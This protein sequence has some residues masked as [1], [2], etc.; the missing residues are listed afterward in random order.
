MKTCRLSFIAE[1]QFKTR[2][3]AIFDY[4][5]QAAL[6]P[7]HNWAM[8]KLKGMNT[9]IAY[10]HQRGHSILLERTRKG[11][12]VGTSDA[13]TWTDRFPVIPQLALIKRSFGWKLILLWFVCVPLREFIL[14]A[15]IIKYLVGQPMGAYS[16]WAISTLAHHALVEYSAIECGITYFRDYLVLGDDVAIFNEKVYNKYISTCKLLGL[17]LNTNKSTVSK[18]SAEIAKRLYF[19]GLEVSPL[20]LVQMSSVWDDPTQIFIFLERIQQLGYHSSISCSF[21]LRLVPP[22]S[23]RNLVLILHSPLAKHIK[24]IV[25][26]SE[27][28][29]LLPANAPLVTEERID[30]E[31]W[32]NAL[33][34]AAQ[35][36]LVSEV[37]RLSKRITSSSTS[38]SIHPKMSKNQ[39][40]RV[41]DCVKTILD[42]R[43]D[44]SY[45][46]ETLAHK[47]SLVAIE[48]HQLFEGEITTWT[49]A[50][51]AI[52][53]NV[54]DSDQLLVSKQNKR[55]VKLKVDWVVNSYKS[56][57]CS[58]AI[59]E[60][61]Y[62]EINGI[63]TILMQF[64]AKSIGTSRVVGH[65]RKSELHD[66][67]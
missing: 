14:K 29:K 42:A 64:A 27:A 17:E 16:S 41:K 25:W 13:T 5:T 10:N 40:R 19:K 62:E 22:K 11:L 34:R 56:Y 20:S 6:L 55:A 23:R 46:S 35:R 12:F 8:L 50:E 32:L 57:L 61:T 24:C 51:Y 36:A 38:C 26:D 39:W 28:R 2:V 18:F 58:S 21:I 15:R 45:I 48:L 59:E 9:S 66:T 63:T 7:I 65:G 53:L 37:S 33:G 30:H 43:I 31:R 1:K 54:L 67:L 52:I 4:W 3:V 49:L 60:V 44:S 47:Q